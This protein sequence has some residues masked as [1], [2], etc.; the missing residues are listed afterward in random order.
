MKADN[1]PKVSILIPSYNHAD[2]I[3]KT[4]RSV[5][6]QGYPNLELI[7]V[8]DGSTD[9]SREVIARLIEISP[10]E[11]KFVEQKNAGICRTLN[12]AL[13]LSTGQII[14]FLASD[15]TMLSDRLNQEA[16][17][18]ESELSLKVLYSS[19]RYQS[20][21]KS[22]G[23]VHKDIKP[24]LKRG[25]ACTRAYLLSTAPGFY[26][27][28]MLIKREFL[29]SLG[30]FDEV[31]GSDD[32][33]LNIRIFQALMF[34]DEFMFL[35]RFAFAYRVHGAQMH[36][37]SDFMTPMKHKVIRK[38]F[39]LEN[40]SKYVCQNF[41]KKSINLFFQRRFK[42]CGRYVTK[43]F[44]IAFSKGI[45]YIC[46]IRFGIAFPGYAFREFVRRLK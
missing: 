4:I 23:D 46:L 33:S 11:I 2:F 29:L 21:D 25:I 17:W 14:G 20:E 8:D 15:D 22:F 30:G 28:A 45:P 5:W 13:E 35:D 32:W 43:V 34:Q 12:R 24:Y 1:H 38:Y 18:F 6:D 19:G 27:Q 26:I 7:I 16:V 39:S 40:R 9:N 3:E 44:N 41:I 37:V 10:I 31:T 42:Q 36:R